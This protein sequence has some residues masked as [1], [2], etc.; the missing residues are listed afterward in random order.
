MTVLDLTR[1]DVLV[2]DDQADIREVGA[3]D[4]ATKPFNPLDLAKRVR[5][6]IGMNADQRRTCRETRLQQALVLQQVE[7]AF[8]RRR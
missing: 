4:Y 7:E 5:E 2:V 6:V 3:V 1:P 8:A